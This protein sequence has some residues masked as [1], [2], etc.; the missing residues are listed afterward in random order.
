MQHPTEPARNRRLD[1]VRAA[2]PAW[3]ISK[4][5]GYRR[6][7]GWIAKGKGLQIYAPTLTELDAALAELEYEP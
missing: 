6:R 5:T 1:E 2:H 7:V 3:F 4:T